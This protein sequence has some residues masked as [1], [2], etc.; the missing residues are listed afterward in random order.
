MSLIPKWSSV[1][2]ARKN[3]VDRKNLTEETNKRAITQATGE[4]FNTKRKLRP[5]DNALAKTLIKI[6]EG[7]SNG[8]KKR[9]RRK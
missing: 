9:Q 1:N 5:I 2:I 7:S 3:N 6:N 8:N 4:L